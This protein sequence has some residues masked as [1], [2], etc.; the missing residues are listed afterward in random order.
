MGGNGS[1]TR[2]VSF[3]LD[4]DEKVAV[5][6]G[7]K[8]S[9]DVL[10]RMRESKGSDSAKL[11][12][13]TSDSHKPPPSPKPSTAEKQEEIRQNF[14]RQQALVQEQLARLAQRE[15]ETSAAAG[16]DE[17]TPALIRERGRAREEQEKAKIV[18]KQLERKEKELASISSF[19]KEQLE[20][21]EKRNLDN[22]KQTAEQ[23]NEAATKAE[24]HIRPRQTAPLCT[25]LQAKVL[26]CYTENPQQ[27]LHCSS[28]AKQYM[29]CVQQAKKSL[30]TNH[31]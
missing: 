20:I 26:Q 17:L 24:A 14:E 21:L 27:T 10:R 22:Y 28:L 8:L 4:E 31:G 19:Y 5:I 12:P 3:G 18:A 9:E 1:T 30:Q 15:R 11:P 23:Y 2:K 25:E 6:E 16:L 29:T 7:V 13:A